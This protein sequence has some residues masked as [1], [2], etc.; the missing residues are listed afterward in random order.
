MKLRVTILIA[1]IASLTLHLIYVPSVS[2][3]QQGTFQDTLDQWFDGERKGLFVG[4]GLAYARSTISLTT[5]TDSYLLS[6]FYLSPSGETGWSFL[7]LWL[8]PKVGYGFS[9]KIVLFA[10]MPIN[11]F[12]SI[13]INSNGT[14][15]GANLEAMYFL[16]SN[17]Y[18]RGIIGSPLGW[19]G[20][21]L[22][23]FGGIGYQFHRHWA[24]DAV[25]G[26]T[27]ASTTASIFNTT[28]KSTITNPSCQFYPKS[29]L[30][31][32]AMMNRSTFNS[33]P[34]AVTVW[35]DFGKSCS[36]RLFDTST[37]FLTPC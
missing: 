7:T 31:L 2:V 28:T 30:M 5:E 10:S 11:L 8:E 19:S 15:L 29:C 21:S 12:T 34:A 24:V 6:D 9:D 33:K 13:P 4:A 25:L 1:L 17:L 27:T 23:V 26:R 18:L 37:R 35:I 3:A 20:S 14:N 32:V 36:M 16:S 22:Q